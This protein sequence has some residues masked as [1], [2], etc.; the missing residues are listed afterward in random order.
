M[1]IPALVDVT[2]YVIVVT[3]VSIATLKLDEQPLRP[4]I[5]RALYGRRAP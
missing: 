3:A 4:I 1:N 5:V 2:L